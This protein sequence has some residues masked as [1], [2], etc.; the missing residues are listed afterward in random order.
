MRLGYH[1]I[2]SLE[3]LHLHLVSADLDS[4]CLKHKKHWNSFAGPFFVDASALEA[5]LEAKHL[6]G[7]GRGGGQAHSSEGVSATAL[8]AATA[9]L[10]AGGREVSAAAVPAAPVRRSP[11]DAAPPAAAAVA[12]VASAAAA[13]GAAAAAAAALASLEA[14]LEAPLACAAMGGAGLCGCGQA[15][16]TIPA[17]KQHLAEALAARTEQLRRGGR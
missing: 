13:P 3:P 9:V 17:L 15:L 8:A 4:A 1:A 7:G 2:P 12:A 14:L 10:A 6:T 16:R 5:A 11:F